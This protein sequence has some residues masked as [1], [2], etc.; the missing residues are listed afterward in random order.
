VASRLHDAGW[1]VRVLALGRPGEGRE[2][3]RAAAADWARR[4]DVADFSGTV[5]RI[6]AE[7]AVDALFGTGLSRALPSELAESWKAVVDARLTVAVDA[8]SGLCLDTGADLGLVAPADVT[9]TF[10]AAKLGHHLGIGPDV[11]GR[12]V[13]AH[14]GCDA[15]D[16]ADATAARL[17]APRPALLAKTGAAHKYDH[18]HALVLGGGVGRGG[19]ARL[20]AHGA[21]RV[22]AGL[23]TLAVPGA[24]LIE[25]AAR[26]DAVMLR[27]ADG[28]AGVAALLED[29]R[30]SSVVVG[31]GF[32]VGP[33][34]AETVAAVAAAGRPMVL[35]AD[36]LTSFAD[37][38]DALFALCRLAPVVMTPH[39]GEFARLFPDLKDADPVTAVREAAAR[40]GA[41]V[42][43]K[44]RA[45][46][47]AAPSGGPVLVN[48]ATYEHAAPWL[49]TAGAG[50]VLAGIIGGLLARGLRPLEAA[51]QAAWLHAAAARHVGPGLIAEDL[52][53][54]L[55]AV[56]R[57]LLG[58]R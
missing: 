3:A 46:P 35:D 20:A 49:A 42:L 43:L 1:R 38:P 47:I 50:D 27:R 44:G 40:S 25:N 24:A 55:P 21:L 31:P 51:A 32:G 39:A 57:A 15:V 22:G 13:V 18:G 41:T 58:P 12:L 36:A 19:A 37:T 8:P 4:G 10:H 30:V 23:V 33:A 11:C 53:G 48:A 34:T 14:I 45:T 52:P 28:A 17:V 2:A 29:R 16:E 56:L 7:V 26:L 6:E 54:A 5:G 9:V